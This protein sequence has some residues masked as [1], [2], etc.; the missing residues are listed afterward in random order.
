MITK[1]SSLHILWPL[2][3]A[4]VII[5]AACASP[6]TQAPQTP[7]TSE[8]AEI[9]APAAT[10]AVGQ[11]PKGGTITYVNLEPATL[12]PYLRPEQVAWQASALVSTGLVD[13]N[14]S[15]EWI[16][17]LAQEMPSVEKG[18]VSPDGLTV[19]WKLR[20]GL[21]RTTCASPGRY[22][23]TPRAGA[24]LTEGSA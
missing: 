5:L 19:T 10:E 8:P 4:L 13:L 23:A 20:P 22:A 21:H 16:L 6:A 11:T 24:P 12:N 7:L 15:G 2:V 18:T 3:L 9:A 14:S 1:R 17:E